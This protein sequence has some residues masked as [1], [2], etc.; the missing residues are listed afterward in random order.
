M[1]ASTE[2]VSEIAKKL[3]LDTELMLKQIQN[4]RLED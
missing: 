1:S 4:Y 2:E 3:N